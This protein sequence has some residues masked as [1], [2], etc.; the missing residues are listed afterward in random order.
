MPREGKHKERPD[1]SSPKHPGGN[2][3]PYRTR[4]DPAVKS[5]ANDNSPS[6]KDSSNERRRSASPPRSKSPMPEADV[7]RAEPNNQKDAGKEG[8]NS[9]DGAAPSVY[10]HPLQRWFPPGEY[11]MIHED[12]LTPQQLENVQRIWEANDYERAWAERPLV[13]PAWLTE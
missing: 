4:K 1:P 6:S 5:K 11:R 3:L 13:W 2:A 7:K 9:T 10:E 12:D 8:G